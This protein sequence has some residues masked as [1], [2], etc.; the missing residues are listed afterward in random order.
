MV[1]KFFSEVIKWFNKENVTSYSLN[2]IELLF[3]KLSNE[4]DPGSSQMMLKKL[5]YVLMFAKYYIYNNKL[6]SKQ[7]NLNEFIRKLE[8]KY[9]LEG[10]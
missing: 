8:F 6:S 9:H 2:T 4:P 5:N 10:F 3:G 7:G 1:K